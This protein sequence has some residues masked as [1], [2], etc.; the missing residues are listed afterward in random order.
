MGFI[1]SNYV[2]ISSISS[3]FFLSV[4]SLII[5]LIQWCLLISLSACPLHA[6]MPKVCGAYCGIL[7]NFIFL[8]FYHF[9]SFS[10]NPDRAFHGDPAAWKPAKHSTGSA[11]RLRQDFWLV[12][13]SFILIRSH[14][15]IILYEYPNFIIRCLFASIRKMGFI[16][17]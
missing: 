17:V 13:R 7:D 10:T 1:P 16:L 11:N 14:E 12:Y 8:L 15:K 5:A 3:P 4:E 9:I 2:T 6:W